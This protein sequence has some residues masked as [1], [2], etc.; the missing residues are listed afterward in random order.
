MKIILKYKWCL[1]RELDL[2]L[3][4]ILIRLRRVNQ[5][6]TQILSLN[7]IITKKSKK[8]INTR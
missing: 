2:Q 4:K 3:L 5:D 1:C 8:W 7:L 6:T